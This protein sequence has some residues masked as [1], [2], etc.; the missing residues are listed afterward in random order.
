[1]VGLFAFLRSWI[2]KVTTEVS[3]TN[4]RVIKKTG[5]IQRLTAEMNM[6]KVE[7][8]DV[9]QSIL[10]RLLDYGTI[11]IRGTGSGLE[12]LRYIA[13]PLALRSAIIAR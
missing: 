11:V 8:V 10:G 5:L 7:S 3:V 4:K 6:D 13:K 12:G 1:L 9:D 2:R